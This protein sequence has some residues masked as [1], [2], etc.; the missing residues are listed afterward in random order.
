LKTGYITDSFSTLG[1]LASVAYGDPEYF[2]EVQN[3]IYSSSPTRFL[4]M[5][6]PSA[7][8]ADFFG[9]SE[10]LV[11][12]IMSGLEAKYLESS[13]FADYIDIGFG[14]DWR[15]IVRYGISSEFFSAL[16]EQEN[17]GLT[18]SD[19]LGIT[20]SRVLP[21]V[22]DAESLSLDVEGTIL[23]T[24]GV[25]VDVPLMAQIVSNNPQ[26]KLSVPP[27]NS[28]VDLN[29]SVDL[30]SDYR[31]VEFT[32]GYVTP[33]N[34]WKDVAYPGLTSAIIPTTL[35]DSVNQGYVGY[36]SSTPLEAL[37]NPVGAQSIATTGLPVESTSPSNSTGSYLNQF[38]EPL[39]ADRDVYSISLIGETLN[40]YTTF[41]P[42]SMSNGDLL[43]QSQVPQFEDENADPLGGLTSSARNF[44][45]AF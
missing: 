29:N 5:H 17:Y 13:E 34:Y 44:T 43:D 12:A 30:G 27:L 31:G 25:G 9:S 40:G 42:S 3:Q 4:D 14:A 36:P 7:I 33:Q 38:P 21:G 39:Q 26:T 37:F 15:S 1:G 28:R 22:P 35:R 19:Y 23:A 10:R 18:M 16:D 32:T 41:D 45:T 24:A 2:R 11:E 8:L 6:R 20:F